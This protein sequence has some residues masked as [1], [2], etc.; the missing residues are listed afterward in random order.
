MNT[1]NLL[2]VLL[3]TQA[4]LMRPIPQN[5][6]EVELLGRFLATDEDLMSPNQFPGPKLQFGGST[7]RTVAE[8]P[9]YRRFC[10]SQKPEQM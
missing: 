2:R 1:K 7:V 10:G 5:P 6:A 4:R 3:P 9:T 8:F